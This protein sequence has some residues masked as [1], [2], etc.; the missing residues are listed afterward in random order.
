MTAHT[1]AFL[2]APGHERLVRMSPTEYILSAGPPVRDVRMLPPPAPDAGFWPSTPALVLWYERRLVRGGQDRLAY[3]LF[4]RVALDPGAAI[5]GVVWRSIYT[6]H[7]RPD[8]IRALSLTWAADRYALV[9]VDGRVLALTAAPDAL[10]SVRQLAV[11]AEAAGLG[12][13]VAVDEH[14]RE[15]ADG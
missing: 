14:G 8:A 3:A 7:W 9:A 13:P 10:S 15:V 4:D 5:A 1:L 2:P 12:R 6:G 11:V